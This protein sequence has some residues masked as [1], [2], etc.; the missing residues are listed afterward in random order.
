MSRH[1]SRVLL[2]RYRKPLGDPRFH[3]AQNEKKQLNVGFTQ[4]TKLK[5]P[6]GVE[7]VRHQIPLKATAQAVLDDKD[8]FMKYVT[9]R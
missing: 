2:R 1:K 3:A 4:N 5:N 6:V 7:N 8:N 9:Y